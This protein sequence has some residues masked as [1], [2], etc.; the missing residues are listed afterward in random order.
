MRRVAFHFILLTVSVLCNGARG[1]DFLELPRNIE[2]TP[3]FKTEE[4]DIGGQ[5][6]YRILTEHYEITAARSEDG[7]LAGEKLEHLFYVWKLLSADFIEEVKDKPLQRRLR[8]VLYRDKQEYIDNL[9]RLDPLIDRTNGFYFAP[10][11]T[12]YFFSPEAKVLFHEGTHQ[13]LVEHFFHEKVPVF[14]NNI[15][16]IEGIAL[17]METLN[18]KDKS[19]K[20]GNLFDDRLYAA[21]VYRFEQN[22][23]LP[24]RKMAAMSAA[25]IQTSADIV[26][27]YSQS[28]TLVYWLM[29][30][31][32]GRYRKPLFELL[33]QTYH[34]S[35]KPETL[36]KLTSLSYE[37]LDKKYVEFLKTVPK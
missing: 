16:V 24:I 6:R 1:N 10:R 36:S 14:R 21:T 2:Q 30:M 7:T 29:F 22:Y 11:K 34:D 35:A 15:W 4:I 5:K 13:I 20:I 17:L 27:I 37:E 31:E 26:K 25:E 33:R 28:A 32:E 23:N 8:V 9:L 3:A 19:Y 12:A 18:I